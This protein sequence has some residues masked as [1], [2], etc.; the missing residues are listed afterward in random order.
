MF[1]NVHVALKIPK[2]WGLDLA[3]RK[4][5]GGCLPAHQQPHKHP[6]QGGSKG[7]ACH[8]CRK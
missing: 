2:V 7:H 4:G 1:T 6:G 3:W 8:Y 5:G